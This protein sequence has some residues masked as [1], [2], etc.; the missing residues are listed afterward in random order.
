MRFSVTF[1]LDVDA[2]AMLAQAIANGPHGG[3]FDNK[4]VGSVI[5]GM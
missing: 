3:G 5:F 4:R 1:P 2:Q